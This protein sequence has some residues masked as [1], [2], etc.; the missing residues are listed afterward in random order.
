M[1]THAYHDTC[2]YK[3]IDTAT[4]LCLVQLYTVEGKVIQATIYNASEAGLDL[5]DDEPFFLSNQM[6][7]RYNSHT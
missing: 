7:I 5:R 4:H 6:T 2:S 3:S 1:H